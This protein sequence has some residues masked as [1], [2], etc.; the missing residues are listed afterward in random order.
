MPV[1]D[2]NFTFHIM[3]CSE[4]KINKIGRNITG[5]YCHSGSSK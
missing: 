4:N 5:G 3:S 2:E 1:I